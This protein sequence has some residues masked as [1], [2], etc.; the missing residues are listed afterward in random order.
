MN[1]KSLAEVKKEVN[2]KLDIVDIAELKE[3]K[4][5]KREPKSFFKV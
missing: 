5:E 1:T 3:G 2:K 4:N